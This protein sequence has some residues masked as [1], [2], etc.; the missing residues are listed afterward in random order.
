MHILQGHRRSYFIL[1]IDCMQTS[2]AV[3]SRATSYCETEAVTPDKSV[4]ALSI[5]VL[6]M[7]GLLLPQL[8]A[9]FKMSHS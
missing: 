8:L 6:C 5:R 2:A 7:H 1:T 3:T 4:S 9:R